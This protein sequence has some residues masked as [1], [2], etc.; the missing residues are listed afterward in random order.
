[1]ANREFLRKDRE[2]LWELDQITN[3][4]IEVQ[5]VLNEFE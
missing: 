4:I 1:M 2:M 5:K 3:V